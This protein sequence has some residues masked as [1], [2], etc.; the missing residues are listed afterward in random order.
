M[1]VILKLAGKVIFKIKMKD[2]RLLKIFKNKSGRLKRFFNR[3]VRK[4][5]AKD[6]KLK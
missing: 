5:K 4:D 1:M 6:T 2:N 3:K